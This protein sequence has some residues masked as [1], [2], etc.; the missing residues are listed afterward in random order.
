MFYFLCKHSPKEMP[1]YY[2]KCSLKVL[3]ILIGQNVPQGKQR[4]DA[5]QKWRPIEERGS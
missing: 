1:A 2:Y 5:T 3:A 4:K